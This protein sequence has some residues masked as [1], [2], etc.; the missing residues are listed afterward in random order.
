MPSH[1]TTGSKQDLCS[2]C[3]HCTWSNIRRQTDHKWL[4]VRKTCRHN[5][6]K[7]YRA[8]HFNFPVLNCDYYSCSPQYDKSTTKGVADQATLAVT[9]DIYREQP[10]R[11]T[12]T[13]NGGDILSEK[14]SKI[15]E[16][17]NVEAFMK[18]SEEVPVRGKVSEEKLL[19]F[20]T[21]KGK[22]TGAIAK[23]CEVTYSAMWSRLNRLH[24]AGTVLRK[25]YEGRAFWMKRPDNVEPQVVAE[26]PAETIPEE[27]EAEDFV[28]K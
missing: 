7:Y 18:L 8:H 22:P 2:T 10:N 11:H 3:F 12:L 21:D 24:K 13:T 14:K 4:G 26:K 9:K 6:S 15:P 5:K 16:E 27:V 19:A 23:H 28:A 25:F 1:P 17:I 20:I